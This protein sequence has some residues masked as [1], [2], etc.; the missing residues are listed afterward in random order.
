MVKVII[1]FYFDRKV[2]SK[3]GDFLRVGGVGVW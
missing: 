3:C 1:I 2:R